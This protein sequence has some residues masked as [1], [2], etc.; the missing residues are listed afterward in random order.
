MAGRRHDTCRKCAA[1]LL[2]ALVPSAAGGPAGA[3]EDP[4]HSADGDLVSGVEG[5]K[6]ALVRIEVSALAEI[7]HVDHTTGEVAVARG[8]Y[9]VPIRTATGVLVSSEGVIATAAPVLTVTDDQVVVHAANT[10]FQEQIGTA[11][12][13][14]DGDPS[15]PAQA[16]DPYWAPHLQHCY[17]QQ[18]H[19][20]LFFEP[21]FQVVPYTQDGVG[22]PA[23]P[24]STSGGPADVGLLR[25][26]GGGGTPT[27]EV[28]DPGQEV[29]EHGLLLGFTEPPA[30]GVPAA[31]VGVHTDAATGA[32]SVEGDLSTTEA[33][34]TGGPV[35]DPATGAVVGLATTVDGTATLVPAQ[36]LHDAF[37]AAGV[38]PSG[39]EFDAVFRR[40]VDHLVSGHGQGP[41][42]SAFQEA[43]SYYDS[44]LAA[45]YL[46]E[47]RAAGGTGADTA[48]AADD[49]GSP[50][51]S[52]VTWVALGVLVLLA[53]LAA[54]LFLR[55]RRA[56]GD[57]PGAAVPPSPP[58]PSPR[59][60]SPPP[61]APTT[62]APRPEQ[63]PVPAST[64]RPAAWGQLPATAPAEAPAGD[65]EP[66]ERDGVR[67]REAP[68]GVGDPQPPSR[69]S[70][71][72]C[73]DCGGTVREN[74]R[75]CAWCGSPVT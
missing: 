5:S 22:T 70:V 25:I 16:V 64:G 54:A 51:G 13:G 26:S 27:A 8:R 37:A 14:N 69:R 4:V 67:V 53:L 57:R 19:C 44:A 36:A 11:L 46:E 35:V 50:F 49:D 12:V 72:F 38:E 73:S 60:P 23:N 32:L 62:A 41:A 74:A 15:R 52:A 56:R 45:R 55:R 7:A 17:E 66:A 43:L 3:A 28:A 29:A 63:V 48:S 47:A 24:V 68:A 21:H 42:A 31:E 1:V 40:G 71:A 30:P 65:D 20:I 6:A 39:S 34:L 9:T 33:A 75:F 18:E 61:P 10:L 58:P 2:L 59:A